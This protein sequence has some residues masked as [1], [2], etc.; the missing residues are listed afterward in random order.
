[1]SSIRKSKPFQML[2][3][4]IEKK[5]ERGKDYTRSKATKDTTYHE[6]A[7]DARE[8]RRRE[9]HAF[10]KM[11]RKITGMIQVTAKAKPSMSAKGNECVRKHEFET[12]QVSSLRYDRAKVFVQ[13]SACKSKFDK[14]C[15]PMWY[16]MKAEH[17]GRERMEWSERVKINE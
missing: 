11:S 15:S 6:R 13:A 7:I 9:R 4:C 5:K 1:M 10:A 14:C 17:V 16:M 12:I 3:A 2:R 8:R